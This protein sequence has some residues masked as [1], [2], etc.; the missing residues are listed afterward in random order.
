MLDQMLCIVAR[1]FGRYFISIRFFDV[2]IF[3]LVEL[4]FYSDDY[5]NIILLF[6]ELQI[7]FYRIEFSLIY[8]LDF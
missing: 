1:C 2:I 6:V 8:D 7:L 4:S 3:A 5:W